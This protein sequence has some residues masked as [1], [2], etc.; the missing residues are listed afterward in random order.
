MCTRPDE[1]RVECTLD[2][3]KGKR[4]PIIPF[5]NVPFRRPAS[6]NQA[7]RL[8]TTKDQQKNDMRDIYST[9]CYAEARCNAFQKR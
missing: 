1:D 2:M 8:L 3:S 5:C 6:T 9:S 4:T 7:R